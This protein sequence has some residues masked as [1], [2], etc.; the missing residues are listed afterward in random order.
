MSLYT[1]LQTGQ[2]SKKICEEVSCMGNSPVMQ[3]KDDSFVE[4]LGRL[5]PYAELCQ[6]LGQYSTALPSINMTK[7]LKKG[8]KVN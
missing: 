1:V 4:V 5:S 3:E 7:N 8:W 2:I 6:I